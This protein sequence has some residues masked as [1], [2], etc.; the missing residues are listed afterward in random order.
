MVFVHKDFEVV[1]QK[2]NTYVE[3]A[4]KFIKKHKR[5]QYV[6]HIEKLPDDKWCLVFKL[7]PSSHESVKE[8][9]RIVEKGKK[10]LWLNNLN[11]T[12]QG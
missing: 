4:K 10:D 1:I 8:Y 11:E 3:L 12:I 9:N 2:M 5:Y 7:L 6:K